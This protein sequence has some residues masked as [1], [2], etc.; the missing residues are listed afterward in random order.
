[1]QKLW[2]GF[3]QGSG[4]GTW[5]LSRCLNSVFLCRGRHANCQATSWHW[6]QDFLH[7]HDAPYCVW[8][9]P[10]QCSSLPLLP[11][12]HVPAPGCRGTE[13]LGRPVDL[14]ALLLDQRGLRQLWKE[15]TNSHPNQENQ[16][17]NGFQ[18]LLGISAHC[19]LWNCHI[20]RLSN[21]NRNWGRGR[22]MHR[23]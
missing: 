10:L 2:N 12:A 14:G 17:L 23:H 16:G 8:G 7:L 6:L 4:L 1:M 9:L 21:R 19:V 3:Q 22:H 15:L 13:D 11:A 5:D 20:R 18:V